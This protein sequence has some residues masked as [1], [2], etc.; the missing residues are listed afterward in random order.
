MPV[1][2]T[3]DEGPNHNPNRNAPGSYSV[4]TFD[5]IALWKKTISRRR[6]WMAGRPWSGPPPEYCAIRP[7]VTNEINGLVRDFELNRNNLMDLAYVR[8]L[9]RAVLR[10]SEV[11]GA[12]AEQRDAWQDI[13]DHLPAYPTLTVNGKEEFVD[14]AEQ[15]SRP[16]YNHCTPLSPM[17]PA[18]DPDVYHDPRLRQIG[19]NSFGAGGWNGYPL[20]VARIRLGM[21]REAYEGVKEFARQH[22]RNVEGLSHHRTDLAFVICE[23]LVTAWDGVLRV[24][25]GWPLET[26]AR[27]RDL[28]TKGAFL[29]SASCADGAVESVEILSERG[30][31]LRVHPPW[32][33]TTVVRVSTGQEAPAEMRDGLL[34]LSTGAGERYALRPR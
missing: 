2:S 6:F 23:M 11:L 9:M 15:P 29:V 25:P 18:E 7:T 5:L 24:F 31:P 26:E 30:N 28:R 20:A 22:R 10:A 33:E 19:I 27:F 8:F 14:H 32:E 17:W 4:A 13:L 34:C 1:V 16:A 21:K 3:G 12:D